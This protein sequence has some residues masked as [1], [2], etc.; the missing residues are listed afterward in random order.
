MHARTD[1]EIDVKVPSGIKSSRFLAT[2]G[3][4]EWNEESNKA[5]E[6]VLMRQIRDKFVFEQNDINLCV[7]KWFFDNLDLEQHGDDVMVPMWNCWQMNSRIMS[8]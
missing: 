3:S 5:L 4:S 1:A 6:R 2:Q 8:W 7:Y